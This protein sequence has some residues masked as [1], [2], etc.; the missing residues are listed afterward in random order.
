MDKKLIELEE[1]FAFLDHTIEELNNVVFRQMQKI[2]E[3][4]EMIKHLSTQIEQLK[5]NPED[6]A[7][8]ANE[9]PPHY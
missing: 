8:V 1:K 6:S 2:D 9:R 3:L 4:E 5:D 7:K